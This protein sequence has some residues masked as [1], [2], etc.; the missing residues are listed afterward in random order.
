M[1][2]NYMKYV[3]CLAFLLFVTGTSLTARDIRKIDSLLTEAY[4]RDQAVREASVDLMNRLNRAG[5]DQVPASVID[6]LMLLQEQTRRIDREN[7]VLAASVLKDG[8]PEGMSPRSYKAIWLIVDHAGL[9]FQKKYLPAM[10]EA[11]RSG[12]IGAD[13]FAVLTDR[14]RMKEGKPQR[15]GTQ[16]YTVTVDGKQVVYIWPVE[17]ARKL[18]ELRR[19]IGAV[20]IEAYVGLLQETFG[21][22]VVYDPELTV[23]QMKKRGLLKGG[24]VG[25]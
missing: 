3:V 15:Y 23:R 19:E 2:K 7:Q 14:I 25:E 12:L 16:S 10:E 20:P 18:G 11:A 22:E 1:K 24:R 13:D 21:C 8:L 5:A 9:K 6:S 17:D 4:A